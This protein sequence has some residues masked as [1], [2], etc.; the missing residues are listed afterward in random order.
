MYS[1]KLI[2]ILESK[3]SN[4]DWHSTFTKTSKLLMK[5]PICNLETSTN[6]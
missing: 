1:K 2:K 3:C 5:H 4:K 6:N